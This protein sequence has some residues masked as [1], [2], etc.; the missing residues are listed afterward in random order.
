MSKAQIK[1][2]IMSGSALGSILRRLLPKLIKPAISL[3]KN[4]RAP[5]GLSA[6]MEQQFMEQQYFLIMK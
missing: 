2:I 5:L 1:K 6:A 4:I 3:G